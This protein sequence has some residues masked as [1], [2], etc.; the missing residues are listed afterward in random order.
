[1]KRNKN[2]KLTYRVVGDGENER[3]S[4]E[5][6]DEKKEEQSKRWAERLNGIEEN[7]SL[8]DSTSKTTPVTEQKQNEKRRQLLVGRGGDNPGVGGL[9]GLKG[10]SGGVIRVKIEEHGVVCVVVCER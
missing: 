7:P 2:R 6:N 8:H 10:D 1:M 9:E 4:E 5:Q 3:A